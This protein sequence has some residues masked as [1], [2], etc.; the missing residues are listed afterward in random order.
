MILKYKSQIKLALLIS[1]IWTVIIAVMIG[2]YQNTGGRNLLYIDNTEYIKVY[3]PTEDKLLPGTTLTE[4]NSKTVEYNAKDIKNQ[5]QLLTTE[6]FS[7]KKVLNT[8]LKDEPIYLKDVMD[9]KVD[10]ANTIPVAIPIDVFSSVAYTI[11]I[12]DYVDINITNGKLGAEN[13]TKEEIAVGPDGKKIT[14]NFFR[15]ISKK[16]VDELK[17]DKGANTEKLDGVIPTRAIVHLTDEEFDM[18]KDADG[19]GS[20]FLGIYEDPTMQPREV[21]WTLN[22]YKTFIKKEK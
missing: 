16:R 8:L 13:R 14:N 5:D 1:G 20:W 18:Y 9:E 2:I 10:Y 4:L 6:K 3:V 7:N 22:K 19:L 11:K 12:G 15:V 21:N 17:T